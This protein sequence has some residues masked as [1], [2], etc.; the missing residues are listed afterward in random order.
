[1]TLIEAPRGAEFSP[2]RA[3]RFLLWRRWGAIRHYATFVMLNPSTADEVQ[4]D[5]TVERCERRAVA[6]GFAGFYVVNIFALRSTDPRA[7]YAHHDP[8]GAGNNDAILRAARD[9]SLVICAWGAHG[10]HRGRGAEVL[11]ILRAAG[12]RPFALRMNADGTPAHPLYLPY[13]A[14]PFEIPEACR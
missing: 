5:P 8:V 12:V 4:N 14:E 3:Y 13:S 11:E 7:L 2:C 6:M 10:K 9:S 1:M